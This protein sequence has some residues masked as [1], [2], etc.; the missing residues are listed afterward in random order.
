MTSDTNFIQK[1]WAHNCTT[2]FWL[3]FFHQQQSRSQ[4]KTRAQSSQESI[5]CAD[6]LNR[7]E[8]RARPASRPTCASAT[9]AQAIPNQVTSAAAVKK[10]KSATIQLSG[11]GKSVS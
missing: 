3:R 2:T 10:K 11:T 7:P 1:C 9:A 4:N 5:L 8:A 6:L